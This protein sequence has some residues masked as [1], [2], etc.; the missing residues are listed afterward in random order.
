[1][2]GAKDNPELA[3]VR[4]ILLKVQRLGVEPEE[5]PAGA[6]PV[7]AG[8]A[9]KA[10]A[11]PPRVANIAVFDRKA[12]AIQKSGPETR[13][14]TRLPLYLGAAGALVAAIAIL[15]ATGI[16]SPPGEAPALSHQ[17]EDALLTDARRL[18]SEGNVS[19]AR[20]LLLRG[21]AGAH[22]DVAFVLAQSY[23]PNYMQSLPNANSTPD[24]SEAARWY[25]K[26]YEL[27]VRSGL[28]MDPGRLQRVINAMPKH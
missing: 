17:E 20:A 5:A 23:D 6:D 27:A 2:R 7:P 19:S 21:G 13:P 8:P 16:M 14:K 10:Q 3:E 24:P 26:W 15:F 11:G 25:K 4:A 9:A 28:E 22:A 1:M 18:L 12:K